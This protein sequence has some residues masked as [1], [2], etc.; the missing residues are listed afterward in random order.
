MAWTSLGRTMWAE[1]VSRSRVW[2][3]KPP[4]TRH[5]VCVS[6]NIHGD[7]LRKRKRGRYGPSYKNVFWVLLTIIEEN[8]KEIRGRHNSIRWGR[9]DPFAKGKGIFNIQLTIVSSCLECK[10]FSIL[11]EPPKKRPCTDVYAYCLI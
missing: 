2:N 6:G 7:D 8:S 11:A 4:L 9:T 3:G 10:G 1:C 5:S